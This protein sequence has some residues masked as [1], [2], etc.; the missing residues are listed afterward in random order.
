M[1]INVI[2]RRPGWSHAALAVSVVHSFAGRAP[3]K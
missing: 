3:G 2:G 1:G